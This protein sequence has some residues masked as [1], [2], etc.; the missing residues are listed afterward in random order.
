MT[1][2]YTALINTAA[3]EHGF[4]AYASGAPYPHCVIDEFFLPEIAKELETEFP[5]F[6]SD[7]WHQYNNAIEIKKVC[8]NW[9]VFPA[10]TYNVFSE[11]NSPEFCEW[12]GSLAAIDRLYSDSGLNGG[13]WHIHRAGGKLNVHL[14][15]SIHPKVPLERKVNLLVY[16]NSAWQES[17]NGNLGLWEADLEN[18]KPGLLAKT[19]APKFNRA[20][21][22]DTT[23]NSW[24]GLPDAITCPDDQYRKSLAVYYLTT[25]AVSADP[26]SKALFA[27]TKEQENDESVLEL[28]RKRASTELAQ[29][30]YNEE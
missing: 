19:I 7:V 17:W 30:V 20:V 21:F 15:Y 22:F 6:D 14:D 12:I 24:H 16:L 8:N 18:D 9:N 13:G 4:R 23:C 5:A 29:T 2:A 3:V 26:R 11:L 27:P 10:T 25:P 28:I 1:A